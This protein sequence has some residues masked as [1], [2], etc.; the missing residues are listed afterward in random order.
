MLR[1]INSRGRREGMSEDIK[2]LIEHI[3]KQVGEAFKILDKAE[4]EYSDRTDEIRSL[5]QE[6]IYDLSA[7]QEE[8][9]DE[10]E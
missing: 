10:N 1:I 6:N 5:L 8:L 9:E 3:N 4:R 2:I 7:I